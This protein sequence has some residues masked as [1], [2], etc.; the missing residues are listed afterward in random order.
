MVTGLAGWGGGVWTREGRGRER[1]SGRDA[2]WVGGT[3][4]L[5]IRTRLG[6]DAT[7][8]GETGAYETGTRSE[9][10]RGARD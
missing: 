10:N 1:G 5:G 6:Q 2:T 7:G 8:V 3:G 9:R 4:V